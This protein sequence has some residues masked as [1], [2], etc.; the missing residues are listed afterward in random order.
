M[1]S[2]AIFLA[3]ALA[4]VV[5]VPSLGT[6][7]V[8][9][10]PAE[11]LTFAQATDKGQVGK[12]FVLPA[13]R[14]AGNRVCFTSRSAAQLT[15]PSVR[16]QG[17]KF[18]VTW[19]ANG[20]TNYPGYLFPSGPM[21]ERMIAVTVDFPTNLTE[22]SLFCGINAA[23]GTISFK[24]VQ[25]EILG[26][27]TVLKEKER[28]VP[29]VIREGP[30]WKRPQKPVPLTIVPGSVLDLSD[31]AEPSFGALT[32]RDG[33]FVGPDGRLVRLFADA[34]VLFRRVTGFHGHKPEFDTD[35][36]IEEFVREL[37]RR[38]FNMVR[39]H[40]TDATLMM[41]SGE[42]FVPNPKMT[43]RFC[44]FVE[45]L[46]RH[47]VYLNTDVMA[48]EIGWYAG[49]TWGD[50]KKWKHRVGK[51]GIY[52]SPEARAAWRKGCEV[53]FGLDNPYTGRKLRD[54]P[55]LA[56][57]VAYN[58]QEFGFS[59]HGGRYDDC[60]PLY[61][62]WLAR[63]YG[64]IGRLN[65]VRGTAYA[66]F[67]DVPAFTAA[68]RDHPESAVGYDVVRFMDAA[69]LS[70]T[71]KYGEWMREIAP[72]C[73][74]SNWNMAQDLRQMS[75]RRFCDYVAIN[76]YH[77]HPFGVWKGDDG[78]IKRQESRSAVELTGKFARS[79]AACRLQGKPF[80]VTEYSIGWWNRHRYEMG[81]LMGGYAALQGWDGLTPFSENVTITKDPCPAAT[82]EHWRDPVLQAGNFLTALAY[83]RG[84]VRESDLK[85]RWTVDRRALLA[86]RNADQALSAAQSEMGLVGSVALAVDEP[87]E[88]DA[89]AMPAVPGSAI[90]FRNEGF[91]TPADTLA[92]YTNASGAKIVAALRREGRLSP[93]NATDPSRGVFES[94]T[95][96]LLLSATNAYLRVNTPRLQGVCAK[97]G[98]AEGLA[99]VKVLE[100]SRAGNLFVAAREGLKPIRTANRLVV[101]YVTDAQNTGLTLASAKGDRLVD[102][103]KLPLLYATGSFRV[104]VRTDRAQALKAWAVADD[105]ARLQELPLKRRAGSVELSVDTAALPCGPVFY[106]ELAE[107]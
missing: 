78:A 79:F 5:A 92:S 19:T 75:L 74:I 53:L 96:E 15:P 72:R 42:D 68:D 67:D 64:E 40:F 76:G 71:R 91:Q 86:S 17:G 81:F 25:F 59:A 104:E 33:R 102:P 43:D 98:P 4:A 3:A 6:E 85:I 9:G 7:S 103:G 62:T 94:S 41:G 48:S 80:V 10:V 97:G 16:W 90:V 55:C 30:T 50:P 99:D 65:A 83:R 18:M 61:R 29:V 87:P 66:S 106:F 70:L 44:K 1:N 73:F 56:M 105:G 101:G 88:K 21:D 51:R 20:K 34:Q 77:A 47:H 82:F 27:V 57:A 2:S 69:Q 22:A 45:L 89:Y 28:P 35:E 63:M 100:M 46:N 60:L 38:G 23:A 95:G 36:R 31:L 24:D 12:A 84:D 11:G 107:R 52:L 49:E 13:A 8:A 26:E 14:F 32:I 54:E 37:K 93:D 58:E 39:S